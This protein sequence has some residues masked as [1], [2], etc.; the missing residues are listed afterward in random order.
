MG[1]EIAGLVIVA[2][3]IGYVLLP[4]VLVELRDARTPRSVVCPETKETVLVSLDPRKAV[5]SLI[6]VEPP[7]VVSCTRWPAAAGC[8][9][10]CEGSI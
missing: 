3:A 7:C 4:A 2:I 1:L 10:T 5:R 9:R 8:H 6:V